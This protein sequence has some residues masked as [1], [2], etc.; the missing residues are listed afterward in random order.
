L[1][2]GTRFQINGGGSAHIILSNKWRVFTYT[3]K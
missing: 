1:Y 2:P 3:V